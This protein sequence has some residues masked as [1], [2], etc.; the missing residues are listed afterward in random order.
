[1]PT[2]FSTR[3]VMRASFAALVLGAVFAGAVGTIWYVHNDH[4]ETRLV[5]AS[6]PLNF[7]L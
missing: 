7:R 2:P 4:H 5:R 3:L 6:S 1:M